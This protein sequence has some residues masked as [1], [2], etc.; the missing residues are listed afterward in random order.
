MKNI[1]T[2][3]FH[4]IWDKIHIPAHRLIADGPAVRPA[5]ALP[6]HMVDYA[7]AIQERFLKIHGGGW[8]DEHRI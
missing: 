3:D 1:G 5:V 4:E 6:T 7:I 2:A 8:Y